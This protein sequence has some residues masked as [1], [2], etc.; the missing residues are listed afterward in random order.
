M[1][2]HK[3]VLHETL[4]L[5]NRCRLRYDFVH[6]VAPRLFDELWF[7]MPSASDDLRLLE[8]VFPKELS[9]LLSCFIPIDDWHAAIHKYQIIPYIV[10]IISV[11][12]CLNGF[13][14]TAPTVNNLQ[15]I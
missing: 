11:F 7:H 6:L 4:N 3:C 14:A 13:L 1:L 9:N 5:L 2:V 8:I 10:F 15:Q 12:N